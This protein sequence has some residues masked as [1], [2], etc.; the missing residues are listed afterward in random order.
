M[1]LLA[2]FGEISG[3]LKQISEVQVRLKSSGAT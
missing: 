1:H 3:A 2:H